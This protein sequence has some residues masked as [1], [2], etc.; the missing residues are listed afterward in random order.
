MKSLTG[1]PALILANLSVFIYWL[2]PS[3]L[4]I[5]YSLHN[6]Y[7][8][9]DEIMIFLPAIAMLSSVVLSIKINKSAGEY[10]FY[11][12]VIVLAIAVCFSI[13]GDLRFVYENATLLLSAGIFPGAIAMIYVFR[14]SERNTGPI[15]LSLSFSWSFKLAFIA[16]TF[17]I[18]TGE[19]IP[20]WLC[21]CLL[22][23]ILANLITVGYV[24][25]HSER[26]KHTSQ[27]LVLW[28]LSFFLPLI[29][30]CADLVA[31]GFPTPK[32]FYD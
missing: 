6:D 28:L 2:C 30:L 29:L 23:D 3:F 8:S 26:H 12:F 31:S 14:R 27:C 1:K 9:F 24:L 7:L 16:K 11:T 17:L 22:L 18:Y 5:K 13:R 21:V 32:N 20:T 15:M 25:R 4:I 19:F 10:Y